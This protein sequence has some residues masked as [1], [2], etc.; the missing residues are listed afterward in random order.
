[1]ARGRTPCRVVLMPWIF[2]V[3]VLAHLSS[4]PRSRSSS[5][6]PDGFASADALRE[7]LRER[8]TG[9]RQRP[10]CLSNSTATERRALGW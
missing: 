3:L 10:G 1:M 5:T 6:S 2:A 8:I 9:S 7:A 4:A